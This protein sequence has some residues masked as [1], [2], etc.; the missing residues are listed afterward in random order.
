MRRRKPNPTQIPL[1]TALAHLNGGGWTI[2]G[3][4]LA[5]DPATRVEVTS[6]HQVEP[7][8]LEFWWDTDEV[9]I[10]MD[11]AGITIT[12]DD[13]A[14]PRHLSFLAPW[15]V[16]EQRKKAEGGGWHE[17]QRERPSVTLMSLRAV[18]QD[19]ADFAEARRLA[20]ADRQTRAGEEQRRREQQRFTNV[21]AFLAL[22]MRQIG[23][24][25]VSKLTADLGSLTIHFENGHSL[26]ID[27]DGGDTCDAWV[28]VVSGTG[29]KIRL[30]TG[31]DPDH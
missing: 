8:T 26:R 16:K 17:V 4:R 18:A 3:G 11:T 9:A 27:L 2:T 23:G 20:E 12:V 19:Q 13:E 21:H 10:A 29:E 6:A 5:V 22:Q 25:R 7:G 28:N 24:A 31:L 14:H 15:P 30:D 1:E